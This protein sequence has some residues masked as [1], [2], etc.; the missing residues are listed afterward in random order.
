MK[1]VNSRSQTRTIGS[2]QDI[3]LL[4]AIVVNF[5]GHLYPLSWLM[6]KLHACFLSILIAF[7]HLY[8][9]IEIEPLFGDEIRS[10]FCL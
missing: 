1:K 7:I 3:K 6:F 9:T 10:S 2:I 5:K 4:L 8:K